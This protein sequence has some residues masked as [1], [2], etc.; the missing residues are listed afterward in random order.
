M[1]RTMHGSVQ[2]LLCTHL[3]P[4]SLS[5]QIDMPHQLLVH[6]VV[7]HPDMMDVALQDNG[8]KHI[9]VQHQ[10]P[11]HNIATHSVELDVNLQDKEAILTTF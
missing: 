9:D 4:N 2:S 3:P 10:L 1:L 7:T 5:L 8:A 11:V 6:K